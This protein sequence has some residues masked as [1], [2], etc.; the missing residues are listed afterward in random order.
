M[1]YQD[2]VGGGMLE[3]VLRRRII[4]RRGVLNLNSIVLGRFAI[5]MTFPYV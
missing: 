4:Y 2:Y 3:K 5:S 1:N